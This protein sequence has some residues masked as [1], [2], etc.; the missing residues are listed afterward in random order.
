MPRAKRAVVPERRLFLVDEDRR[1]PTEGTD[2]RI[3]YL[4]SPRSDAKV[5][6]FIPK[7]KERRFLGLKGAPIANHYG[8]YEYFSICH[9]SKWSPTKFQSDDVIMG[10]TGV[11]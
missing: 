8:S 10:S 6:Q 2:D 1:Y 5:V 9:G 4:G 7:I 11:K 3:S